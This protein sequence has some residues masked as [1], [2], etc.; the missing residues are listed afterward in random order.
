MAEAKCSMNIG[1]LFLRAVGANWL[2]KGSDE[3]LITSS[4]FHRDVITLV[5]SLR[6]SKGVCLFF[7]FF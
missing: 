7:F 5:T 4:V 3:V 1:V 2:G 6:M